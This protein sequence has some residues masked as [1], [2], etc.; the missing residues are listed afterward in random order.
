MTELNVDTQDHTSTSAS[1][2]GIMLVMDSH[3]LVT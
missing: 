3:A 2:R 1:V